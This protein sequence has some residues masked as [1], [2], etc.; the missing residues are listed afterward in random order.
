MY[1]GKIY[2][3]LGQRFC[4]VK[5]GNSFSGLLQCAVLSPVLFNV[6]VNNLIDTLE[7]IFGIRTVLFDDDLALWASEAKNN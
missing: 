2:N 5:Y 4:S 1:Q 6:N 3:F 7:C